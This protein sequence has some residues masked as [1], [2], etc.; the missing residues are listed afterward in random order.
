MFAETVGSALGCCGGD[1]SS[2]DET[3]ATVGAGNGGG[4]GV[5]QALASASA[6]SAAVGVAPG[7]EHGDAGDSRAAFRPCSS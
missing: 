3:A 5:F 1:R 7:V 6:A 4:G 2:G